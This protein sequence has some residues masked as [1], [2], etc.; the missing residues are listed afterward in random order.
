MLLELSIT[1]I[2]KR[3]QVL[4]GSDEATQYRFDAMANALDQLALL[5]HRSHEVRGRLAR[6]ERGG[7]LPSG[8]IESTSEALAL[9]DEHVEHKW[10]RLSVKSPIG[11][12]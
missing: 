2:V 3:Y 9:R 7:E 4:A 1:R 11:D 12:H 10:T 6:I 8:A 5:A